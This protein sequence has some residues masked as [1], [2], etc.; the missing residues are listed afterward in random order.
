MAALH[1]FFHKS[2]GLEHELLNEIKAQQANWAFKAQ[3]MLHNKFL[4]LPFKNCPT[5]AIKISSSCVDDRD[6]GIAD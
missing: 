4:A 2:A 3:I 5:R 6:T 1:N